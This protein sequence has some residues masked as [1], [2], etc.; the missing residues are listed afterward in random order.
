M[1]L[2][3]GWRGYGARDYIDH[4]DTAGRQAEIEALTAK[5][6]DDRFARQAAMMP[7]EQ[8]LPSRLRGR[9]ERID[10]PA[11]PAERKS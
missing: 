9:N 11:A 2:P 7:F 10:E 4:P 3:P 6:G 1:E 8:L 5:L